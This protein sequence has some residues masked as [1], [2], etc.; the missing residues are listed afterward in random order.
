ME[1]R[2][3][4]IDPA[5]EP[6]LGQEL[7]QAGLPISDLVGPGKRYFA[8]RDEAGIPIAFGGWEEIGGD[9]VLLRSIVVPKAKRGRGLGRC[10][11]ER[12]MASAGEAGKRRF[13]L[14]T[15]DAADFFA[16]LGF[17][18]MARNNAP[19][20]LKETVQFRSLCPASATLMR[21]SVHRSICASHE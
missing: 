1:G 20:A 5:L 19:A 11:V 12:L 14:L 17:T 21:R 7:A 2:W 15:L 3:V 6:R 8:C 4:E 13:Y 18:S 10:V 9:D 16:Q